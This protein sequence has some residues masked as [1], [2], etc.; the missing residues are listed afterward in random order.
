M[1]SFLMIIVI[2]IVFILAFIGLKEKNDFKKKAKQSGD[3]H[4][5]DTHYLGGHPI[6]TEGT[7]HGGLLINQEEIKFIKVHSISSGGTF[8][9]DTDDILDCSLETKKSI[10]AKRMLLVG[11]LAFALKKGKNYVRIKFEHKLGES[12]VVFNNTKGKNSKIVK[13]INKVRMRNK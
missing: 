10:S 3:K 12:E 13:E 6:E 9:I 5:I 4:F 1:F 7:K 11:L 8:K 2:I